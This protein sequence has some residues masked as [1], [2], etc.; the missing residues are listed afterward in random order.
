M[1]YTERTIQI[2]ILPRNPTVWIPLAGDMQ[3]HL[4]S[5]YAL[6]KTQLT[7]IWLKGL[8]YERK[9]NVSMRISYVNCVHSSCLGSALQRNWGFVWYI[10]NRRGESISLTKSHAIKTS[11]HI[12]NSLCSDSMFRKKS[13]CNLTFC[14]AFLQGQ[15]VLVNMLSMLT[16]CP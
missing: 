7:V 10:F 1:Q 4:N 8:A 16:C 6:S 3:S 12:I 5:K 13:S 14:V 15:A 2:H 9:D 11:N